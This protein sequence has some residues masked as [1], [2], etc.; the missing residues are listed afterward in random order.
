MTNHDFKASHNSF[1]LKKREMIVPGI[2]NFLNYNLWFICQKVSQKSRAL[3]TDKRFMRLRSSRRNIKPFISI[4]YI[5]S[6][7]WQLGNVQMHQ[8]YEIFILWIKLNLKSRTSCFRQEMSQFDCRS[9]VQAL[10]VP[11]GLFKFKL[12]NMNLK[13]QLLFSRK[14]LLQSWGKHCVAKKRRATRWKIALLGRS[15]RRLRMRRMLRML[16]MATMSSYIDDD[17]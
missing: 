16:G 10:S 14:H 4:H 9:S 15:L 5:C 6:I 17:P 3:W 12:P 1:N 7:V 2:C 11:I 13:I 8:V